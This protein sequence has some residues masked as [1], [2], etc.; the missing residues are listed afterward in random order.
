M[1]GAF[2]SEIAVLENENSTSTGNSATGDQN[3]ADK[4]KEF[5]Q[6]QRLAHNAGGETGSNAATSGLV[7]HDEKAREFHEQQSAAHTADT[8]NT[9]SYISPSEDETEGLASTTGS[10]LGHTSTTAQQTSASPGTGLDLGSI[11]SGL[12]TAATA[13]GLA[14]KDALIT[15][16]DAA[17]PVASDAAEQVR[18]TTR[19][20]E[21]LNELTFFSRPR[22]WRYTPRKMPPQQP[23]T[24]R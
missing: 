16:K 18:A 24:R 9:G 15:A 11:G 4:A 7:G 8:Q 19:S 20:A 3:M 21:T 2:P 12:A 23:S 5:A 17:A 1:P 22:T 10:S 6:Q 14:A 13:L